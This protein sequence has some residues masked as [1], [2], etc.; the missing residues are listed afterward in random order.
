M[1]KSSNTT[2]LLLAALE[3]FGQL[4]CIFVICLWIR[5]WISVLYLCLGPDSG[6]NFLAKF[7]TCAFFSLVF[8]DLLRGDSQGTFASKALYYAPIALIAVVLTIVWRTHRRRMASR[9]QDNKHTRA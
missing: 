5:D 3:M 6:P 7:P 8:V 9:H 2:R 4:A 1:L